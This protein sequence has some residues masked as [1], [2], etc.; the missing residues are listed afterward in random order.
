MPNL[1]TK[2]N[3]VKS[4]S[5]MQQSSR[6]KRM[7]TFDSY[8]SSPIGMDQ[9]PVPIVTKNSHFMQTAA[10]SKMNQTVSGFGHL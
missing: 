10:A 1:V 2:N 9:P 8:L 3:F 7:K 4:D 6:T 5:K